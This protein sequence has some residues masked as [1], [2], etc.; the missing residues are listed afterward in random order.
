MD[1]LIKN[2]RD[3]IDCD[4]IPTPTAQFIVDKFEIVGAIV[5]T[6]SHNPIDWNGMKFIDQDG[7]FLSPKKIRNYLK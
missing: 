4:I 7:T 6:A 2:N 3:V 5:I 1:Y